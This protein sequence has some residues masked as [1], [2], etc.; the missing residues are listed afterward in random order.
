MRK[1]NHTTEI[2]SKK[3]VRININSDLIML[4]LTKRF[5][6]L[7]SPI[8]RVARGKFP[9]GNSFFIWCFVQQASII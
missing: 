1:K 4:K 9:H 6:R 7:I 3:G 5:E 2:A 8:K